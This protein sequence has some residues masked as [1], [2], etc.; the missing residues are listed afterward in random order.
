MKA[1]Y[2]ETFEQLF[3]KLKHISL[4]NTLVILFG[5]LM[6]ESIFKQHSFSCDIL[7]VS[8]VSHIPPK[9]FFKFNL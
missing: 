1:K 2:I 7:Y 4:S 9:S 5:N 3:D 8:D 6:I